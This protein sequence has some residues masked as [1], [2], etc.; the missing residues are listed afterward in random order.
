[1]GCSCPEQARAGRGQEKRV[2][3]SQAL[4]DHGPALLKLSLFSNGHLG[5]WRARFPH[6]PQKNS[7]DIAWMPAPQGYF[8]Q[9]VLIFSHA[10]VSTATTSCRTDT[11]LRIMY[12]YQELTKRTTLFL[13]PTLFI[14]LSPLPAALRKPEG[15]GTPARAWL[16]TGQ[17]HP[18]GMAVLPVRDRTK[19][20]CRWQDYRAQGRW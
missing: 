16:A 2:L 5:V 3:L 20:T 10:L 14:A 4:P 11:K 13:L 6:Y 7:L 9:G 19:L 18:A 17:Q 15:R 8:L 12:S 1:M